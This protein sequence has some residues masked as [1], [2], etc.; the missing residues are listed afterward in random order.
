MKFFDTKAELILLPANNVKDKEL[1]EIEANR[2]ELQ[3]RVEKK[4][5]ICCSYFTLWK[6]G[7]IPEGIRTIEKMEEFSQTLKKQ[8]EIEKFALKFNCMTNAKRKEISYSEIVELWN[9]K[10]YSDFYKA[11]VFIDTVSNLTLHTI[12]EILE[13]LDTNIKNGKI[14]EN[15]NIKIQYEPEFDK[16]Y[17][18]ED[19]RMM[20]FVTSKGLYELQH[21]WNTFYLD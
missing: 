11:G 8:K 4:N 5:R 12:S 19:V 20:I 21:K 18:I 7:L 15:S 16:K 13:A 2:K 14:I 1:E 10:D 9:G 6:N 17:R 3:K